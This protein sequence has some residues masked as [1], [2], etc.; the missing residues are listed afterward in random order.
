MPLR[1]PAEERRDKLRLQRTGRGKILN[2][3]YDHCASS[4]VALRRKSAM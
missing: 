3:W 1:K 4:A 2:L